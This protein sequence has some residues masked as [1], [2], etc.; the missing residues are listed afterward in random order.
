MII[1]R[2]A[3]EKKCDCKPITRIHMSR[4]SR[5]TSKLQQEL[6]QYYFGGGVFGP[7]KPSGAFG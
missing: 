4:V 6:S 3:E 5:C 7:N 2:L 1:Y